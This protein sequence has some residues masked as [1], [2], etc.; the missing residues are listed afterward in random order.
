[1]ARKLDVNR[2]SVY[3]WFQS[4]KKARLTNLLHAAGKG[5]SLLQKPAK[6]FLENT[7]LARALKDAPNVGSICETFFLNQMM[8]AGHSV[9][10][11]KKGDF[12]INDKVVMEIGG[13]NKDANQIKDLQNGSITKMRTYS[14][15][16]RPDGLSQTRQVEK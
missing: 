16:Q 6:V 15:Y 1:L 11:P 2:D 5:T 3:V 9:A 4:L 7:N 14:V 10:M 12:L 13:Q 8:N